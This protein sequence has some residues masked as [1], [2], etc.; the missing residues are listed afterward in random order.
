MVESD[1]EE[2]T[3]MPNKSRPRIASQFPLLW[4][5]QVAENRTFEI[6]CRSFQSIPAAKR[7]HGWPKS[8]DLALSRH[9]SQ[10]FIVGERR[11]SLLSSWETNSF[12]L[13][14]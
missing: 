8:K 5:I 13:L 3:P 2:D 4:P 12:M 14:F 10:G 7:G 6:P 11:A 1:D 9:E